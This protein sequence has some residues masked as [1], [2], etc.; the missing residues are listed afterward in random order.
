MLGHLGAIVSSDVC[1]TFWVPE[2]ILLRK[3]C[4][5]FSHRHAPYMAYIAEAA[6]SFRKSLSTVHFPKPSPPSHI[7]VCILARAEGKKDEQN[8]QFASLQLWG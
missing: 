5:A 4:V 6:A 3:K 1:F 2:F 7:T 8:T